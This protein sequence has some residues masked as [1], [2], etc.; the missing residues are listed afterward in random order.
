MACLVQSAA[1]LAVCFCLG[2]VGQYEWQTG[3][4]FDEIRQKMDRVSGDNCEIKHLSDLYLPEDSVSHLPDIKDVNINPVFPNRTALLHLHNMAL[5]RS[6]FWSYILQ[7]RFIRPAINDTYDPGMM[8]YFLSS[9]ADV[10]ANTFIN[11]SATYFSPNMSYSP[12]YRGFFNKTM[13][14]FAPR[15]FRADD[16]N[17]PVHMERI[18][19]RN[20]F[21]VQDLGAFP[22]D[23]PSLDYSEDAYRIN[24]WYASFCFFILSIFIFFRL[25]FM[26]RSDCFLYRELLLVNRYTKW[27]PDNVDQRHDTKTTYQIEIRYANNTNETFSFHGPRGKHC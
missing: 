3:D 26:C 23:S 27:L 2:V 18:S 20:T 16:F 15:T 6:F 7:S 19:T 11:A 24:E 14:R 17:D 13:P 5:S 12:S 22:R 4:A 1:L 25:E 9:V 8:Y 10:S 21:T